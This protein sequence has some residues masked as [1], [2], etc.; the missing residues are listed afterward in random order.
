MDDRVVKF[1]VG[2]VVL[3]TM[4]ILAILVL[5]F[6][7]VGALWVGRYTL[8]IHFPEA[9]GVASETPVRKD[10][11]LIGKVSRVRFADDDKRFHTEGGVIVTASINADRHIH[12]N[13]RCRISSTLI[14]DA[15]LEFVPGGPHPSKELL[16]DDD[17]LEGTVAANPLQMLQNLE[18]NIGE[19]ITSVAG[20]G[21]SLGQLANRVNVMLDNS[22]DQ[23]GR[24]VNKTERAIDTFQA[25]MRGI[26]SVLGTLETA[27]DDAGNPIPAPMPGELP[28][29]P[30]GT[31]AKHPVNLR[32]LMAE[33]RDAVLEMRSAIETANRNLGNLE[34]FT[35]PL[36]DNGATLIAKVDSSVGHLDELL[37]QFVMFGQALNR[38][39]GTIGLL[40]KDPA[41]YQ[42]LNAAACNIE[43]ITRELE[44]IIRDARAFSDKIARH[45]ES[46]GV[47]GALKPNSGI[48]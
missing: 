29:N 21:N 30:D 9:P 26:N 47:R 11:I 46:L 3:S 44:P 5:L 2:V 45:P 43:R 16:K 25:T 12:A 18:G 38:Q 10:G 1:G 28:V 41:L 40:M 31:P 8:Y 42:H 14:G 33:T 48:K 15:M 17:Y 22:G 37:Q 13:E 35:A 32:E 23:L 36:G 24:I 7:D 34:R 27:V 19:A 6:N 39:Q 4:I 20:A